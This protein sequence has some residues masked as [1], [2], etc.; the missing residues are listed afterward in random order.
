MAFCGNCGKEVPEGATLCPACGAE[1]ATGRLPEGEIPPKK[2]RRLLWLILPLLLL[3]L[4]PAALLLFPSLRPAAAL[5]YKTAADRVF[6]VSIGDP[7]GLE[8]LLPPAAW[9]RLAKEQGYKDTSAFQA[10]VKSRV[11]TR[12]KDPAEIT[13]YASVLEKDQL[14]SREEVEQLAA[15]L[16]RQYPSLPRESVTAARWLQLAQSWKENGRSLKKT[17]YMGAVEIDGRWYPL[18]A[19]DNGGV[20][21]Y[22]YAYST[23][24]G[25]FDPE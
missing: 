3:I 14:L 22:L 19:R 11:E 2:R 24:S 4:I 18:P 6:S 1:P 21:P 10:E 16:H 9:Q 13:E 20:A 15:D 8:E 23:F 17:G 5:P 7:A 12:F 25:L